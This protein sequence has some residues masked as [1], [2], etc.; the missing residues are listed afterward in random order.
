MFD[1]LI[2]PFIY[3]DREIMKKLPKVRKIPQNEG[4]VF[5]IVSYPCS[6][7]IPLKMGEIAQLGQ[8]FDII[9][10]ESIIIKRV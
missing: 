8:F 1:R 3:G 6:L 10:Y 4:S 9:Y 5:S 2:E 7:L